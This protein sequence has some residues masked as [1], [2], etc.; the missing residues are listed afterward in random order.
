MAYLYYSVPGPRSQKI[1]NTLLCPSRK[2]AADRPKIVWFRTFLHVPDHTLP[3]LDRRLH[4]RMLKTSAFSRSKTDYR[5]YLFFI[6]AIYTK[7]F[8]ENI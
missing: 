1:N 3:I 8:K 5:C 7:I 2:H 4:M 6:C